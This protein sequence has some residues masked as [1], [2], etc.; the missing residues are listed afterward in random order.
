MKNPSLPFDQGRALA[1]LQQFWHRNFGA[2]VCALALAGLTAFA[3]GDTLTFARGCGQLYDGVLRLHILA[4]SDIEEDQALKLKV[5]DR[6]LQTARELGLGDGCADIDSL[7]AQVQRMLP[8]LLDA[9][10]EELARNGSDDAVTACIT[11]M[12]FD[13]REYEGFTMPAGEYR[14]VRFVIGEG[15]GHNWWCV[16]FPQMCLPVAFEEELGDLGFTTQELRVLT[17]RPQYEPRFA[18]LE[19]FYEAT[20]Q[21]DRA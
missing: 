4:N 2:L 12:Y 10:Q 8:E 11:T 1:R 15:R 6:V 21:N 9:A 17:A 14:A 16:L 3:L 5:R 19:W 7:Q 20:G 18:L 13:T